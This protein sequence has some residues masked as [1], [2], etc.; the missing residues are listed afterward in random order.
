M[1]S[2][3]DQEF[4]GALEVQ[5]VDVWEN[6][7]VAE[8]YNVR[9]V[10]TLVILDPSGKAIGKHEGMAKLE[11]LRVGLKKLGVEPPENES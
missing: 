5:T 7:A 6:Q 1:V 8:R 3:L 2:D 10:P 11:E 4:S 9:V